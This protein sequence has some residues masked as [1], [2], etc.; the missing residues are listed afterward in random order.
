MQKNNLI[1]VQLS[2]VNLNRIYKFCLQNNI[3]I[4]NVKRVDYKNIQFDI[5]KSNFKTLQNIAKNQNYKLTIIKQ[6]GIAKLLSIYSKRVGIFVGLAVFLFVNIFSGFFVWN[7]KIYGNNR[8]LNSQILSVL[9]ANGI[10]NGALFF[11]TDYQKIEQ[12][13]LNKLDELSLCSII[14][15]GSTIIVN[16]KEKLFVNQ[17]LDD[18]KQDIVATQNMTINSLT[19]VQGTALKNN[20][21]SVKAGDVIVAGYF[22]DANGKKVNCKANANIDA[23]VWYSKTVNY[24]KVLQLTKRTGQ[25]ISNSKMSL[26]GLNFT[27]K[28]HK[29]TFDEFEVE[30]T[31]NPVFNNNFLPLYLHTTTYHQI[32]KTFVQQDFFKDKQSLIDNLQTEVINTVPK[33]LTISKTFDTINETDTEYIVTF[34]AEVQIQL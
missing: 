3:T 28:N 30:E 33:N 26:F 6:F 16:V 7:I 4:Y 25:K 22:L 24:P 19:V 32:T 23:T 13:L 15:K 17:F 29:N 11:N 5:T 1:K 18:T 27:V 20:G 8:V 14:K 21:D 2:G 31:I 10:N 12:Q 34:Y 9:K